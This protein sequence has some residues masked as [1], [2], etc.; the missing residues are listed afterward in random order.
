MPKK[1]I[2]ELM[3]IKNNATTDNVS[4]PAKTLAKIIKELET[5]EELNL[6]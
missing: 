2:K 3:T 4:I 1:L 6:K 5:L